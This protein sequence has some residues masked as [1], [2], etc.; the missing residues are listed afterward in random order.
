M[1][2]F[3]KKQFLNES[4]NM[5]LNFRTLFLTFCMKINLHMCVN[6]LYFIKNS[7]NNNKLCKCNINGKINRTVPVYL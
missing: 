3:I 5:F 6:A 4:K 1:H 2:P 7:I